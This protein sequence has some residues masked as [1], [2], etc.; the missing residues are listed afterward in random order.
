MNAPTIVTVLTSPRPGA[1]AVVEV[2][3]PGAIAVAAAVTKPRRFPSLDAVPLAVAIRADFFD[4]DEHV[5]E[6][7]L[8][9]REH[10]AG[11]AVIELHTHGSPRVVQ[12]LVAALGRAGGT[13]SNAPPDD[14]LDALLARARTRRAVEFVL[15][16]AREI[17][18]HVAALRTAG[19]SL[20]PARLLTELDEL[21]VSGPRVERML[22]GITIAL[23]GPPGAG[24]TTLANRLI[25]EDRLLTS[26]EPGTTRDASHEAAALDGVPVTIVDTAGD[27][28]TDEP[29]EREAIR[30]GRTAASVADVCLIVLDHST[31]LP[32]EPHRFIAR[33]SA[34]V[35]AANKCDLPARWTADDVQLTSDIPRVE[36]SARTGAGLDALM[37]VLRDAAGLSDE[38]LTRPALLTNAQRLLVEES[39]A[40]LAAGSL[41]AAL[42][43]LAAWPSLAAGEPPTRR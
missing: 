22:D 8:V 25:G 26:S 28:P 2:A 20:G 4:G 1:I 32:A 7:L 12:R 33:A 24:K 37:T 13:V 39:R 23:V 30:R 35:L 43:R 11:R 17:D 36:V 16:Q 27:R 41:P 34:A 31:P 3:G 38:A 6:G 10:G 9:V 18:R 42:E 21:I 14:H 29:I 40:S 19:A 15:R 5:D